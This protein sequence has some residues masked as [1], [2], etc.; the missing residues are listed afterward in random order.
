MVLEGG[1]SVAARVGTWP[2]ASPAHSKTW[3]RAPEVSWELE[4]VGRDLVRELCP[5]C[6]TGCRAAFSF[7]FSWSTI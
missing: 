4:G 3:N 5:R 6:P 2:P 1:T 7:I